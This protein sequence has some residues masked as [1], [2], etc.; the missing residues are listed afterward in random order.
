[1]NGISRVLKQPQV[2]RYVVPEVAGID[3]QLQGNKWEFPV[4]VSS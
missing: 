4:L 2:H 3:L 1:M